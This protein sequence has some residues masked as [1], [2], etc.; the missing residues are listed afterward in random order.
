MWGKACG[1]TYNEDSVARR[2]IGAGFEKLINGFRNYSITIL[3]FVIFIKTMQKRT[4]TLSLTHGAAQK[5][6]KLRSPCIQTA[7][8][9]CLGLS[10]SCQWVTFNTIQPCLLFQ[11]SFF[12]FCRKKIKKTSYNF[13]CYA[14]SLK[15]KEGSYFILHCMITQP[16]QFSI[17]P[18]EN[19]H[20]IPQFSSVG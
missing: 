18:F 15:Y 13:F 8:E 7:L 10:M 11:A 1:N 16:P 20:N 9:L 5:S 6:K 4:L 12:F 2:L 14:T 17:W 3:R 19:K